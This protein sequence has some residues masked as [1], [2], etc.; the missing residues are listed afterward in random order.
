MLHWLIVLVICSYCYVDFKSIGRHAWR[1]KEKL[2]NQQSVNEKNEE[3]TLTDRSLTEETNVSNEA[4]LRNRGRISNADYAQC[5]C[6][7]KCKGLRGL[8]AHR[9]SCQFVKGM[10]T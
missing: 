2:N 8:K 9:R 1:C 4:V 7:K 10:N 6:G 5:C 3:P